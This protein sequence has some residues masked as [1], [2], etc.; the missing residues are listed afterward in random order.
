[1]IQIPSSWRQ[2]L[3]GGIL[4]TILLA[5]ASNTIND[6]FDKKKVLA[7]GLTVKYIKLVKASPEMPR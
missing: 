5:Q 1:V 3:Y 7:V 2:I 6:F 4:L